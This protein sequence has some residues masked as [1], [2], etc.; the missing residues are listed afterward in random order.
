MSL[1]TSWKDKIEEYVGLRVSLFKLNLIEKLAKL[2]GAVMFG[3]ISMGLGLGVLA[4]IGYGLM[5]SFVQLFDSKVGGAFCTAGVFLLI[6]L[7]VM[8]FRK[9]IINAFASIFINIL[10]NNTDEDAYDS[11]SAKYL[12]D[13]NSDKA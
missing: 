3:F 5:Q 6:I 8:L 11:V 4:F 9:S 1:F 2:I 10:T 12:K 13:Q 7:V